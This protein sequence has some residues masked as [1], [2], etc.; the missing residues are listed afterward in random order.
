MG[1]L[2]ESADDGSI[3]LMNLNLRFDR[4][5][6]QIDPYR[7]A[8]ML[9]IKFLGASYVEKYVGAGIKFHKLRWGQ[10]VAVPMLVAATKRPSILKSVRVQDWGDVVDVALGIGC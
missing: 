4:V 8:Q 1:M 3:T 7:H 5:G 10:A 9:F 2:L 6:F